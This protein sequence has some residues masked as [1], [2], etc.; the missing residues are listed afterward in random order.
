MLDTSLLLTNLK[1]R[2]I[3][4]AKMIWAVMTIVADADVDSVVVVVVVKDV[5]PLRT[6]AVVTDVDKAW[7]TV[8][9]RVKD[10]LWV[11]MAK[12]AAIVDAEDEVVVDSAVAK[13]EWTVRKLRTVIGAIQEDTVSVAAMLNNARTTEA[14]TL[15]AKD[16]DNVV[17]MVAN[18]TM[19]V[20]VEVVVVEEEVQEALDP[21]TM[22]VDIRITEAHATMAATA[23]VVVMVINVE[24]VEVA[25]VVVAAST[26]AAA[27]VVASIRAVVAVVATM[28]VISSELLSPELRQV[29]IVKIAAL[30]EIMIERLKDVRIDTDT[31]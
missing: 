30:R 8:A 31:D 9:H 23:G 21:D 26:R 15:A 29:Q 14:S 20:D 11:M 25:A 6:V 19:V 27:V 13:E 5:V 17:M 28:V 16:N 22:T 3:V 12:K 24:V 7:T 2:S 1:F 4:S 18:V 10:H